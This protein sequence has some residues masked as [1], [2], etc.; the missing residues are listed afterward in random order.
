[1]LNFIN[2]QWEYAADYFSRNLKQMFFIYLGLF[3][4][5]TVFSIVLFAF[6]PDIANVYYQE[7]LKL[8]EEKD[9]LN[10][11]GFA[12][13]ALILGNNVRAGGMI[14]LSGFIPFLFLPIF[15]FI[16]N[17][18]ILGV[19]GA[20]FQSNG[21]GLVPFLAGILPHGIL[22]IPGL[23]LGTI[24]GIHIC[25]KLVKVI[26]RRTVPGEFKQAILAVLRIFL[27]WML[28]LFAIASGIETFLTPLLLNAFL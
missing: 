4:T 1:M 8:F 11:S 26:L 25:Q 12:L 17:A 14:I 9:I 23:V 21:V 16:S 18:M 7:I 5:L 3:I 28:P 27:L 19:M 10:S 15:S 6:N 22:E 13:Y 24:L 20:V 2:L